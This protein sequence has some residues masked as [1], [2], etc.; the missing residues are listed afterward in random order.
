MAYHSTEFVRAIISL[1]PT[2]VPHV[3]FEVVSDENGP[4]ITSWT[5]G[6]IQPTLVQIQAVDTDALSLLPV[7]INSF[8]EIMKVTS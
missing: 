7:G 3:D 4:R 8:A 2:A 1:R 5:H 6:S